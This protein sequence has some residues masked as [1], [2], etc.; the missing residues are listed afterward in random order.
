M[1]AGRIVPDGTALSESTGSGQARGRGPAIL[2]MGCPYYP[3][4][5][6]WHPMK[7]TIDIHDELLARAK[8]HARNRGCSLRSVVE[9]GL[10]QL[11]SRPE[12]R[13]RYRLP[14]LSTGEPEAADPLEAY[15]WQDLRGMIYGEPERH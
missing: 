14:D 1:R 9:E 6:V 3:I 4:L 12:S 10:R 8:Q 13:N 15:S 11:L 7:T 2:D 5:L